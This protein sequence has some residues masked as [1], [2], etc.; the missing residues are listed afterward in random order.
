[1][2]LPRYL[3]STGQIHKGGPKNGAFI[4]ITQQPSIDLDIPGENYTFG[5]LAAA[6]AL[7]DVKALTELGLPVLHI[8]LKNPE[9]RLLQIFI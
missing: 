5:E 1:M 2:N 7:G 9:V 4:Q 8:H 6:Q 3:H